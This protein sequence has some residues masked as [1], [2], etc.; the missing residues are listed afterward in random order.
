[1][2]VNYYFTEHETTRRSFVQRIVWPLKVQM[3]YVFARQSYLRTVVV[4]SGMGELLVMFCFILL[5]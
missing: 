3:P 2:S 1:M 4:S 5:V